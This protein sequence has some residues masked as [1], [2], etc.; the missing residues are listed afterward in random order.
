MRQNVLEARSGSGKEIGDTGNIKRNCSRKQKHNADKRN[1]KIT[2]SSPIDVSKPLINTVLPDLG[3][4]L[5]ELLSLLCK[6]TI[7]SPH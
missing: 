4:D 2:W 5:K 1:L 3:A 7:F 6:Y